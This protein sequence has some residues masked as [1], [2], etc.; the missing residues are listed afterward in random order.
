M[1]DP[2]TGTWSP[3]PL[4]GPDALALKEDLILWPPIVIVHNISLSNNDHNKWKLINID[5]LEEFL[6]GLWHF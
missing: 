3:E 4:P 6:R 2:E 1:P 5:A